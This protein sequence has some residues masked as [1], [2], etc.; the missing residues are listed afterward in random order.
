ML[1]K[2]SKHNI[3]ALVGKANKDSRDAM[4]FFGRISGNR[5]NYDDEFLLIYLN[6]RTSMNSGFL[7]DASHSCQH[8]LQVIALL[9]F[10]MLSS[11][12]LR[13][14]LQGTSSSEREREITLQHI[15]IMLRL[16]D[17]NLHHMLSMLWKRI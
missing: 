10:A 9:L 3:L 14:V 7:G 12:H 6:L 5:K 4:F 15:V 8:I 16:M 17:F 11:D 1:Y 2:E 13:P